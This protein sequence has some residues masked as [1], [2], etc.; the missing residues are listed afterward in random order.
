MK[1][2]KDV[3][4]NG[5]ND[6]AKSKAGKKAGKKGEK[7]GWSK[8]MAWVWPAL[9]AAV[10]MVLTAGVNGDY[11]RKLEDLSYFSSQGWFLDQCQTEPGGL[12]QYAAQFLTQFFYYPWLGAAIFTA[13]LLGLWWLGVKA[14]R[15]TRDMSPFAGLVPAML[16]LFALAPGYAVYYIK[17][18]GLAFIMPVGILCSYIGLIVYNSL[19][20][21]WLRLIWEVLLVLAY[22]YLGFFALLGCALCVV[23]ELL[24]GRCWWV[25]LGGVLMTACEP[26]AYFYLVESH[27]MLAR[28]YVEG[29]PW[30]SHENMGVM[31]SAYTAAGLP[32]VVMVLSAIGRDRKW[33]AWLSSLLMLLAVIAVF[34][35]R[36]NDKNFAVATSMELALRNGDTE[37]VL[38]L[39]SQYDEDTPTRL[40]NMLTH[41]ALFRRSEAGD[42][43]YRFKIGAEPFNDKYPKEMMRE[44]GSHAIYYNYG[45]LNDAYRW[46]MEDMVE[47]GKRIEYLDYMTK[48]SLMNGEMNLARRYAGLLSQTMFHKAEAEKYLKYADNP[49]MVEE[50]PEFKVIRPISRF[51]TQ[52]GSDGGLVEHYLSVGTAMLVGGQPPLVELSLQFNLLRKNIDQFWPRF[53]LYASNHSPLPRHYQEAAILFSTLEHKVDWRQFEISTEVQKDFEEFMKMAQTNA[54]MS[55]EYNLEAFKPRFGNTYWYYYFFINDLK[56]T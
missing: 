42:K 12:V 34:V 41:I 16:L 27:S 17:G 24:N 3:G 29:I 32:P 18:N 20:K 25:I 19:S 37:R 35:F 31:W 39:A 49:E 33:S 1:A 48:C 55:D 7:K 10:S 53:A 43:Q 23:S 2:G 4:I 21:K 9:F 26:L 14:F 44:A 13:L 47:N 38:E 52:I 50:D 45:R 51:V 5:G 56:T 54:N 22:P 6:A 40:V 46:C 11:L 28:A 8:V 30:P 36:Y 15:L